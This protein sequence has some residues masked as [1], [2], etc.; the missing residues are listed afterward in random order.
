[1]PTEPR[2]QREIATAILESAFANAK[3]IEIS[4]LEA[5]AK[6]QGVSRRTLN[7]AARTLS[8]RVILNGRYSGFWERA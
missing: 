3:R 7:R 8:L 6:A 2:T 1:M 4:E 5:E